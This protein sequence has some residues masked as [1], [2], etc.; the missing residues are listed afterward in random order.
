MVNWQC[1]LI[2]NPL[3][4]F[5]N[6]S[7][8]PLCLKFKKILKLKSFGVLKFYRFKELCVRNGC[9]MFEA[10][11]NHFTEAIMNHFTVNQIKSVKSFLVCSLLANYIMFGILLGHF[12]SLL[13]KIGCIPK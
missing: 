13:V 7:L 5:S 3:H 8:K 12:L 11:M 4:G 6:E 2:S 9:V 10:I 1:L